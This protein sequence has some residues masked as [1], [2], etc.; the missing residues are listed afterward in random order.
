MARALL[1]IVSR[2]Q[3]EKVLRR[4]VRAALR[5][6]L[7]ADASYA[8]A[9]EQEAKKRPPSMSR[10]E[11]L[12]FLLWHLQFGGTPLPGV[13]FLIGAAR[14]AAGRYLPRLKEAPPF[15]QSLLRVRRWS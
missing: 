5:L 13:P 7:A 2:P 14:K 10:L 3:L 6:R 8:S 9:W 15:V 12:R 1:R 4:R 11:H